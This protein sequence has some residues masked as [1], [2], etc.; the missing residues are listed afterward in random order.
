MYHKLCTKHSTASS[1]CSCWKHHAQ[2]PV[3]D[4]CIEYSIN[5][6]LQQY[7]NQLQETKTTPTTSQE[8]FNNKNNRELQTKESSMIK[9]R[10]RQQNTVSTQKKMPF[11]WTNHTAEEENWEKI[12]NIQNQIF[13]LPPKRYAIHLIKDKNETQIK[14]QQVNRINSLLTDTHTTLCTGTI[15][16]TNVTFSNNDINSSSKCDLDLTYKHKQQHNTT[17]RNTTNI[18]C[19]SP[20]QTESNLYSREDRKHAISN[21]QHRGN[22]SFN[23]SI[24]ENRRRNETSSSPK[25]ATS[26]GIPDNSTADTYAI[27]CI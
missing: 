10:K 1:T 13:T 15:S 20:T 5:E 7:N 27:L 11:L 2:C 16:K 18:T 6:Y 4:L 21:T 12:T 8:D 17:R 22:D 23:G 14:D 19:T 26:M 3:S 25:P 9:T 24:N